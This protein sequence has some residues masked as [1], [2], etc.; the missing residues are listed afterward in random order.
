MV[1]LSLRERVGVRALR[2]VR[3]PCLLTYAASLG[4]HGVRTLRL[5]VVL[6]LI[7]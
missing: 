2:R 1:S 3:T 5:C 4:T 7:R 6:A